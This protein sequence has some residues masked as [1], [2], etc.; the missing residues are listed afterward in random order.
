MRDHFAV[1]VRETDLRSPID[2]IEVDD[3]QVRIKGNRDMIELAIVPPQTS[4]F[5]G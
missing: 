5:D 1:A 2:M 3:D 4:D